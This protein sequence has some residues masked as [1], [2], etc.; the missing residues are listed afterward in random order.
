[1]F[2]IEKQTMHLKIASLNLK[3]FWERERRFPQII[4][5]FKERDPD[6]IVLQEVRFDYQFSKDNTLDLI[7]QKLDYH[8][9]NY[10]KCF[11]FAEDYGKWIKIN[12]ETG[13]PDIVDEWL[14]IISKLPFSL[15]VVNLPIEKGSDRWPR[16]A[17]QCNFWDFTL[18]NLHYSP[19]DSALFQRKQTPK[20]DIIIWD[21]NIKPFQIKE[22]LW[23]YVSSY[24]F[25]QYIS[26]PSEENTFDY[27]LLK[28]GKFNN[29]EIVDGLSDHVWL[30]FEVEI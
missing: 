9:S 26:Y 16:I 12:K 4:S 17:Q 11:N 18:L 10:T 19:S 7:N 27:C 24:N 20:E 30:F 6:I 8:Y 25:K 3:W 29:I 5:F 13:S 1:M 14:W 15:S 22:L 23:D 28:N 21:F 2:Y